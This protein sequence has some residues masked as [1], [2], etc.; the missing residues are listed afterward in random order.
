M[1]RSPKEPVRP[2]FA[3]ARGFIRVRNPEGTVC[4]WRERSEI[5]ALLEAGWLLACRG[6]VMSRSGGTAT[7]SG[8]SAARLNPDLEKTIFGGG[9]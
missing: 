2:A 3:E 9:K 8:T 5:D 6:R 4:A 1:A 7:G